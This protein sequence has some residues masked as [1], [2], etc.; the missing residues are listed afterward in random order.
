MSPPALPVP[1]N[2]ERFPELH[3]AL[4]SQSAIAEANRCLFCF[5]APCAAAC[6]THIDVPRFIKKIS[7]GNLRGSA[8]TIFDA[9]ILGLSC[10]RVCP[11]DVLCEGSC[12]MHG[13]NKKPI[14]IGRLQRYAMDHFY[15]NTRALPVPISEPRPSEVGQAVPP[16]S[17]ASG[18][19]FHGLSASGSGLLPR[20][21]CIGGGPASLSCAAELRRH[22][23]PVTV[24]DNRP[25]PGGLN[26]YGVAEYKLRPSDSLREVDLI[27]SLGVEFRQAEIGDTVQLED[28][29]KEFSFVFVGVGLGAMERLGIPGEHLRGVIDAL[30][31]IERYKTSP[32]F[33]VGRRVVVIG[34]GNTAIDAANASKRLGAEEVHIFYRR[35][36]K[37]MPAFSFEYDRSKV[38]GVRFHWLA[39]PVEIMGQ[40]GRAAAVKFAETRLGLPDL[41]GRRKAEAVEGSYFE[42][43]CDMVIPALGQSRFMGML[44]AARG[45][46]LKGGSIV[47]DRPTGRTTN[48]K[49]Y[50][51]GDCVNGGREVVDAVADGKRAA[52]AI[53]AQPSFP[54]MEATH[55]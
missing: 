20:I 54:P 55:G 8:L 21:A 2:L 38:E 29:E 53:V 13:Y 44:S 18:R 45:I 11:V 3:P 52:L 34:G 12:V 23:Y 24:F 1:L 42:C 40:D 33:A 16:A 31:F 7:T 14:E 6:P 19:F 37:E 27:R 28:L 35:S 5:D 49:Y 26:T 36:E 43:A 10:S 48:P 25:L 17:P 46:E 41:S 32:D 30:R 4:D 50:A 15:A 51:G 39:Q 47:V 9:N 22:G